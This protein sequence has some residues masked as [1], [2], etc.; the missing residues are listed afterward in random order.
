LTT[1]ALR[2]T[3]LRIAVVGSDGISTE[4]NDAAEAQIELSL[5]E[6]LNET[7]VTGYRAKRQ[8]NTGIAEVVFID[9][10]LAQSHGQ[11]YFYSRIAPLNPAG[12][13]SIKS[14]FEAFVSVAKEPCLSYNRVEKAGNIKLSATWID[15][16]ATEDETQTCITKGLY[17][18]MG[19]NAQDL[20][21]EKQ[22]SENGMKMYGFSEKFREFLSFHYLDSILPGNS[23]NDLEQIL[24]DTQAS[25]R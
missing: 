24:R 6:I 23:K 4:K 21:L 20:E 7:A 1:I 5:S 25:C 19:L 16:S 8:T 13:Q 22:A 9:R 2:K 15:I 3:N 14:L 10:D 17:G 18:A 12:D 11:L